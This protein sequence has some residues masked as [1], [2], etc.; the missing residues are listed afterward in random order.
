MIANSNSAA[1]AAAEAA[2]G[3]PIVDV[4]VCADRLVRRAARALHSGDTNQMLVVAAR[5]YRLA[6]RRKARG[7]RAFLAHTAC[8]LY[9]AAG[10]VD[11]ATGAE[12][13]CRLALGLD[14]N[15]PRAVT[16]AAGHVHA[17]PQ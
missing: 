4:N 14:V 17:S 16:L 11:L 10:R 3:G 1:I 9:R 13:L 15:G 12:M 2:K 8:Q 5:C 7:Y 6:T